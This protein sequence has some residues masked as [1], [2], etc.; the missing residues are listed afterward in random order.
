MGRSCWRSMLL[1]SCTGQYWLPTGHHSLE[2]CSAACSRQRSSNKGMIFMSRYGFVACAGREHWASGILP[3]ALA[4]GNNTVSW[5]AISSASLAPNQCW[6]R[7]LR[8]FMRW[9]CMRAGHLHDR[10]RAGRRGLSQLAAAAVGLPGRAPPRQPVQAN[11]PARHPLRQD[12]HP[13][14]PKGVPP[15][16][17]AF[18][19]PTPA[20]LSTETYLALLGDDA[21]S[22][23]VALMS[24]H[25][26]GSV[27][28]SLSAILMSTCC[29]PALFGTSYDAVQSPLP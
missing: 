17:A 28:A 8:S 18:T 2:S 10:G 5:A 13:H 12:H 25:K 7:K 20:C 9:L 19:R 6:A 16:L 26:K 14:L 24:R 29:M 1:G 4:V 23:Q 11:A 22:A 3:H 15:S 21:T 27:P